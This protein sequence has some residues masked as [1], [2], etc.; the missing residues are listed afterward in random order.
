MTHI[1]TYLNVLFFCDDVI[2]VLLLLLL[3][4]HIGYPDLSARSQSERFDDSNPDSDAAIQIWIVFRCPNLT[5]DYALNQHQAE[6][7]Q[8]NNNASTCKTI[9][10]K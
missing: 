5:M 4:F 9:Q 6:N 1:S 10:S 3:E 2:M 8:H 7:M